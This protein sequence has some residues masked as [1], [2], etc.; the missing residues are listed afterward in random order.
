MRTSALKIPDDIL[1]ASRMSPKDIVVE[2]AI[3]LFET[4]KLSIGKAKSLAKMSLWEFQNLL[5]SRGIPVSYDVDD[6]HDDIETLK[7]LK[8]N[9]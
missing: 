7:K 5:A 4:G 9:P 1:L 3:H 6:Y 8:K 2:L